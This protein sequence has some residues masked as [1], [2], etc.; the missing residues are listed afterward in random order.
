MTKYTDVPPFEIPLSTA[1]L[2]G[3]L[4]IVVVS[5]YFIRSFPDIHPYALLHQ[6]AISPI[7]NPTE[8]AVYR[9]TLTPFTYPLIHGLNIREDHKIRDGDLRDIWALAKHAKI[10]CY[11]PSS[12]SIEYFDYGTL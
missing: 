6:S 2:F 1:V 7:R 10:G 9:S 4:I 8:S 3:V 12:V 11:N 5:P